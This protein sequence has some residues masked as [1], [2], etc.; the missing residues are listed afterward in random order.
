[1]TAR[2]DF[3][4]DFLWMKGRIPKIEGILSHLSCLQGVAA[5][6]WKT[7]PLR[8]TAMIYVALKTVV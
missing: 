7:S 4:R 3:L 5:L 8:L 6:T 2:H 1:M